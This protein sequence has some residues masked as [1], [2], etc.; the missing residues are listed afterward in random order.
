MNDRLSEYHFNRYAK[1]E[2]IGAILKSYIGANIDILVT[3]VMDGCELGANAYATSSITV[4]ENIVDCISLK[5]RMKFNNSPY[6]SEKE[7]E[8]MLSFGGKFVPTSVPFENILAITLLDNTAF[9]ITF[10][11]IGNPDIVD[12]KP[13]KS[14]LR[15]VK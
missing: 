15:V 4:Q 12:D 1:E 10:P 8:C 3:C 2:A 9:S 5:Y 6:A 11:Y 14:F 7:I 13:K